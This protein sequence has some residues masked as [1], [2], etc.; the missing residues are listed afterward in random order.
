MDY[1]SYLSSYLSSP[2]WNQ[3]YEATLPLNFLAP[4]ESKYPRYPGRLNFNHLAWLFDNR[5]SLRQKQK[6]SDALTEHFW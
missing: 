6:I 3:P 1:N 4:R 2:I 5:L